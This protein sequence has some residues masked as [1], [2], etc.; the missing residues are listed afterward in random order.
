MLGAGFDHS[1]GNGSQGG[2]AWGSGL[3]CSLMGKSPT[4]IAFG[5]SGIYILTAGGVQTSASDCSTWTSV[6]LGDT[7]VEI[8]AGTAFGCARTAGK[9]VY[10]WGT[11]PPVLTNA[12]PTEIVLP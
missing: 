8:G 3:G 9:K 2:V 7:A 10:C 4:Q 6:T 12:P 11:L 5:K 1:A